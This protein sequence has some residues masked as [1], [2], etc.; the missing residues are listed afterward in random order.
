MLNDGIQILVENA[1]EAS[2]IAIGSESGRNRNGGPNG[3]EKGTS[4]KEHFT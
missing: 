2:P 4:H 1:F 3:K